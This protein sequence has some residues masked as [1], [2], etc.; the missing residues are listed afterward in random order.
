ME[1]EQLAGGVEVLGV[2]AGVVR[3]RIDARLEDHDDLF[4][5]AVARAFADAVDGALDLPRAG[6]D[7][8]QRI[9]HRQA[10]IVMAVDADDGA[11]AQRLDDAADQRAV[12]LGRRVADGIGNVDRARSGGD[13]RLRDLLQEIGI[14]AR[15]VLRR[16]FDVVDVAASQFDRGHGFVEHLL[17]GFLELVLEVDIA[18]GDEGV[19]ARALGMRQGLGGALHIERAAAR[20]RGHLGP[21]K[22]AADRIDGF[23][24]AFAGDGEAGFEDIHA[25]LHQLARHGQLF[26]YGHAA[27]GRL[28]AIAQRRVENIYA[29]AH[30][31]NYREPVGRFGKFIILAVHISACYSQKR[32]YGTSFS[33][34]VSCSCDRKELFPSG[35]KT[36]PDAAGGVTG[37]A[38]VGAGTG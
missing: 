17:L 37:V 4:E 19:D 29:I 38:A 25:E 10:E 36:A 34:G 15:A 9:G 2:N 27:A 11:I 22:L 12:F 32:S 7:R 14:G 31:F 21:G 13:H 6:F 8:G 3:V 28:L 35:G 24:I 20:Q 1:L 18:G 23:E 16:K 5:R 33:P 26:R 30:R